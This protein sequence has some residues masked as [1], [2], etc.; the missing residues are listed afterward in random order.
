MTKQY[1]RR[2]F[3]IKDTFAGIY[4]QVHLAQNKKFAFFCKNTVQS[5]QTWGFVQRKILRYNTRHK[6][7]PEEKRMKKRIIE[8]I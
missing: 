8:R 2:L 5:I 1:P 4:V 6:A 3:Q 7:V